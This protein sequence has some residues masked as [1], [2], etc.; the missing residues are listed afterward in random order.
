VSVLLFG[1]NPGLTLY[2]DAAGPPVA[3][4]SVWRVDWSARGAGSALV[5][6]HAGR[7]RVVT[8]APELGGW[9]ADAFTRHFPEVE[10]LPWPEPEITEAPVTIE[11]DHRTGLRAAAA[12]VDVRIGG[13]LDRRVVTVASFPGNGLRL[14]NVY[15][16]CRSGSLQLGGRPVAG[17]PRVTDVP[18]ASSTAFLADAEVW[19]SA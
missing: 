19:C 5:V 15:V 11:L 16:P 7:V 18:R 2:G 4:A 9:L 8:A 12:D 6:W 10:G 1:A 13:P 17:A 3:F 14:S